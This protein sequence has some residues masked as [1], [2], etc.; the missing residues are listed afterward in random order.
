L[1]AGNPKRLFCLAA[2]LAALAW[3]ICAY[4]AN[5]VGSVAPFAGQAPPPITPRVLLEFAPPSEIEARDL[6][7]DDGSAIVITWRTSPSQPEGVRY[8]VYYSEGPDRCTTLKGPMVRSS[9]CPLIS[10]P[11]RRTRT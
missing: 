7:N 3:A 4:A 9:R 1:S 8:T 5:D 6:P 11:S 10:A 2:A